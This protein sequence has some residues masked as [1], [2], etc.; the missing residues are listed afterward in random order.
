MLSFLTGVHYFILRYSK[1][2]LKRANFD[3]VLKANTR[4]RLEK[5]VFPVSPQKI[6][7]VC[8]LAT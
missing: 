6:L 5:K 4:S 7:Y 8:F 3:A 1:G 2:A